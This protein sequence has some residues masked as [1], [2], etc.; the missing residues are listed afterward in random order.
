MEKMIEAPDT[1]RQIDR[2]LKE[3]ADNGD[4]YV[5]SLHGAPIAAVVPIALYRRWQRDRDAF[6]ARLEAI[7]SRDSTDPEEADALAEE[8]VR[9]ARQAQG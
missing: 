4:H 2:I 7:P 6:F 1:P 8:A 3:V 5:V 9:W